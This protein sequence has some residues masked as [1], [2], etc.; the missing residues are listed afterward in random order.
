MEHEVMLAPSKTADVTKLNYP[1]M[2]QPKYDG[3]RCTYI[4]GVGFL[5][6]TGKTFRNEN[7]EKY[8]ESMFSVSQVVLDGE[9]FVPDTPFQEL[10]TV[11]SAAGRP[12]TVALKFAAFDALPIADWNARKSSLEY[13]ARLR[14]LR[15]T[16]AAI[17]DYDKVLDTPTDIV[18]N[19]GEVVEIYK[20]YLKSGHEG[21]MIRSIDG[22]YQWKRVTAKS[23]A[24]LK[25]KPFFSDDLKV[26]G[27]FDGEGRLEGMAGG[28]VVCTDTG[29]TVWVG[30]GFTD[31]QRKEISANKDSYIGKIAEIKYMGKTTDGSLRHP[32]FERWRDDK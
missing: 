17:A 8:F 1:L 22:L 23:G 6:R 10:S 5:S 26:T 3:F 32:V 20:K 16:V 30:T 12:I 15:T 18:N 29:V 19:S 28:I 14:L 9:L 31:D 4:P 25:L 2:V 7:L 21:A 27:V 13:S 11:V 24:L